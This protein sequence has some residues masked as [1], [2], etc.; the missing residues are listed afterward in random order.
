MPVERFDADSH[1]VRGAERRNLKAVASASDK[2]YPESLRSCEAWA[3]SSV[4]LPI[5][6]LEFDLQARCF[7]DG[8]S[9]A[10]TRLS[11]TPIGV[12]VRRRAAHLDIAL[13]PAA[14]G[15]GRTDPL[16]FDYQERW[17]QV[18][19]PAT[20]RHLRWLEA[21]TQ[22][23]NEAS[24]TD[25]VTLFTQAQARLR[26]LSLMHHTLVLPARIALSALADLALAHELVSTPLDALGLLAGFPNA[27]TRAATRLWRF[28]RTVS[29]TTPPGSQITK[30]LP[31]I[32]QEGDGYGL[33][34]P[35]WLDDPAVP[36][37][38]TRLYADCNE[39]QS[40]H[41]AR[42]RAVEQRIALEDHVARRLRGKASSVRERFEKAM[43]QARSA[44]AVLEEHAPL[45][46][47]H[48]PGQVRRLALSLGGALVRTRWLERPGDLLFLFLEDLS[49]AR[50][51]A[52]T[53]C[54]LAAARQLEMTVP[55]RP[56]GSGGTSSRPDPFAATTFGS[57]VQRIYGTSVSTPS[58]S[59]VIRG[60]PA[61]AG[62]AAG[63][64]RHVQ[65]QQDL[66]LVHPGEVLVVPDAGA[67][68][69]FVFP[70]LRAVIT[71]AGSPF[72]HC[73]TLA[74]DCALPAVVGAA[75]A[76]EL[77]DGDLVLV[78]GSDGT[79]RRLL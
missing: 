43:Q 70:A 60:H 16:F 65:L 49:T 6:P 23:A 31:P 19:R 25:V 36:L 10:L 12:G 74:R 8:F 67:A 11:G 77:R 51:H 1:A 22:D 47:G 46:H 45:M 58:G 40:P 38:I 14:P 75:A 52:A 41:R 39:M 20:V 68:W 57:L 66:R 37:S 55:D 59:H 35:G 78:N 13:V 48:F 7:A 69:S 72:G 76:G 3:P 2:V 27:A 26:S 44:V 4:P 33:Q 62:S 56:L 24:A 54:D 29:A 28:G 30:G 71:R 17:F 63:R 9:E 42:Q 61:S 15:R 5:A 53:L 32:A 21:V 79:V 18:V 34:H 50:E 73:A 64:V